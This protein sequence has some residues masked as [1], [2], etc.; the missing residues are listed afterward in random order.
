MSSLASARSSSV[1]GDKRVGTLK[2]GG[3]VA[4]KPVCCTD[5]MARGELVNGCSSRMALWPPGTLV[6]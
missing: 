2:F 5:G 1:L 4:A 3:Q 6:V